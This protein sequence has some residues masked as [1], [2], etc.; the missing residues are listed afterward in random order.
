M[1]TLLFDDIDTTTQGF[2]QIGD[3]AA[4]EKWGRLRTCFDQ[5]VQ[6]TVRTRVTSGEG[7]EYFYTRDAMTPGDC[8]DA[9]AIERM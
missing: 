4:R 6:I 9:I 3:E 5:K 1:Q 7:A 8:E 2:F